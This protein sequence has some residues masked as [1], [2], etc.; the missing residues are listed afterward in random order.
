MGGSKMGSKADGGGALNA[1]KEGTCTTASA[2]G[3]ATGTNREGRPGSPGDPRGSSVTTEDATWVALPRI[4]RYP[5]HQ[6]LAEKQCPAA[7]VRMSHCSVR[8][9]HAYHL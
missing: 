5:K 2:V 9:C 3:V 1:A 8:P 7:H 4:S 6:G